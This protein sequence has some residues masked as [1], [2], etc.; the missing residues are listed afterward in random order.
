MATAGPNG[1]IQ[2]YQIETQIVGQAGKGLSHK[3]EI[4]FEETSLVIYK[5]VKKR[6]N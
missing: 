6:R 5:L 3:N 4:L 1:C 2:I